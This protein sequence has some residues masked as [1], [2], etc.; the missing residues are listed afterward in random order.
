MDDISVSSKKPSTL[1]LGVSLI[2]AV[3]TCSS[4]GVVFDSLTA[5]GLLTIFLMIM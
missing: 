2:F 1:I 5:Q 3:T 4:A